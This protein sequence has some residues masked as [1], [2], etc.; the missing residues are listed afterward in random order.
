MPKS[1]TKTTRQIV[2]VLALLSTLLV[3]RPADAGVWYQTLFDWMHV[4]VFGFVSLFLLCLMPPSWADGKRAGAALAVAIFLGAAVELIQIP[5]HRNASIHDVISDGTGAAAFLLVALGVRKKALVSAASIAVASLLLAWSATALLAASKAIAK[6]NSQFPV[7]YSGDF[8]AEE[9]LLA[10]SNVRMETRWSSSRGKLYTRIQFVR[11]A[12]PRLEMRNLVNDWSNYSDLNL[13]FE[14]ESSQDVEMT[15]RIYDDQHRSGNQPYD[16]RFNRRFTL[17]P[18]VSKLNIPL[19]DIR[20][21]PSGRT[22]NLS[23]IDALIIFSSAHDSNLVV[24]L[25]EIKLD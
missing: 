3:Y 19:R 7:L 25:Y 11:G 8:D 2:A 23:E 21:A 24:N 10:S 1:D 5:L 22:M 13:N 12:A 15:I 6:R 18:G 9:L 16:D 4:P 14:L 17:Q 20:N